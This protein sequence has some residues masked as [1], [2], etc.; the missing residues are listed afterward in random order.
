[1]PAA[2]ELTADAV[3]KVRQATRAATAKEPEFLGDPV[4]AGKQDQ[5]HDGDAGIYGHRAGN[6]PDDARASPG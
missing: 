4:S 3:K 2:V 5:K 1:M 6:L